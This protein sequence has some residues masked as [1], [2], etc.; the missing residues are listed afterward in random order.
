VIKFK[1]RDEMNRREFL[2]RG[3]IGTTSTILA[4]NVLTDALQAY[5][6]LEQKT[7]PTP[8]YRIL[9]RTGL[10][11]SIIGFGAMLTPEP[12]V[13]RV[14]F[15]H[16][17]NYV[18]TSRKYMAG[19]N[20]EIVGKALKGFRSKV[21][22]ATKIETELNTKEAIFKDVE[23][24]LKA[25]GTDYIDVIQLDANA[26]KDRIFR[27]EPRE[28]FA[29]L[30]EQ[31]KIRFCG[32]AVHKNPL[33]VVNSVVEDKSRFFDTIMVSYNFKS[34]KELTDAISRA[35]K[36]GMGI[37]AMKTQIGGYDTSALGSISHHQA[38]LK[39]VLQNP[40]IA[41]TIP[42]MK[43]LTELTENMAVM[44]MQLKARDQRILQ[45]YSKGI[46]PYYCHLC[47]AC[48][49]SCPQG[50][51]ISSVNRSLMY[52]E[53]YCNRDLALST[54]QEIPPTSRALVC[55]DCTECIA[56]CSNGLNIS[57]KMERAR[58]LFG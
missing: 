53:G 27:P 56:H 35:A 58:E 48:E 43:S 36:I 22:V 26:D 32:V 21:F 45:T 40:D 24:S 13:I 39:W 1:N 52:E 47:G 31:G 30:K 11:V 23:A 2:K 7:F 28:A 46:Q 17:V 25:L 18:N 29:K 34:E 42:G 33:G 57:A 49:G 16:G 54:Y 5:A 41:T 12:E 14:A 20:E 44:G 4:G 15:E 55:T 51:E 19:K 38:A 9:G 3:L 10:K 50:V 8:V 37:I 6:Q